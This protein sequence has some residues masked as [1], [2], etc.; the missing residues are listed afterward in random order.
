VL[1]GASE[2]E[3][4]AARASRLTATTNALLVLG[5]VLPLAGLAP[6]VE[7]STSAALA[8]AVPT[9]PTIAIASSP[10]LLGHSSPW[11]NIHKVRADRKEWTEE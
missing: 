10:L 3:I 5:E 2:A 8:A 11:I 4:R 9:R 6:V 1:L 7:V